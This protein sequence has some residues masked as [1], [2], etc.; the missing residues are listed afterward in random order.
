MHTR[1]QHRGQSVPMGVSETGHCPIEAEMHAT[2]SMEVSFA[3]GR[4]TDEKD[5]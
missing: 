3:K 5:A 1:P 4:E 2:S